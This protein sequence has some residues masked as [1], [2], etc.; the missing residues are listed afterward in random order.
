MEDKV[1]PQRSVS[2]YSLKT[3]GKVV[4][5][6]IICLIGL[7]SAKLIQFKRHSTIFTWYWILWSSEQLMLIVLM[8]LIITIYILF[9]NVYYI[10][11]FT[12]LNIDLIKIDVILLNLN[13]V[14][15]FFL[16]GGAYVRGGGGGKHRWGKCRDTNLSLFCSRQIFTNIP[17]IFNTFLIS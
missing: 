1:N 11:S 4:I 3:K 12:S 17:Y 9:I 7:L 14:Y 15:Y 5:I 10:S 8:C 6:I 16:G 13:V 2:G